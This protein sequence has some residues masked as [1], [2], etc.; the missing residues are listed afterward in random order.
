[1]YLSIC[2]K[3]N[4]EAKISVG[5]ELRNLKQ[6]WNLMKSLSKT[7][8]ESSNHSREIDIIVPAKKLEQGKSYIRNVTMLPQNYIGLHSL[9]IV[10]KV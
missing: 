4:H 8:K 2:N 7:K 6:L 9:T 3:V 5:E 1:M 10:F